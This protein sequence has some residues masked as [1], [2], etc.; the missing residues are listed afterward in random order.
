MTLYSVYCR[1]IVLHVRPISKDSVHKWGTIYLHALWLQNRSAQCLEDSQGTTRGICISSYSLKN[2]VC[3][4]FKSHSSRRCLSSSF[5]VVLSYVGRCLATGWS[6]IQGI[7]PVFFMR[8]NS[9]KIVYLDRVL[10]TENQ[11]SLVMWFVQIWDGVI[12]ICRYA[13]KF[14]CGLIKM[15]VKTVILF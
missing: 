14:T 13:A 8:E 7:V 2:M 11:I 10:L 1:R 12:T 15:F 6:L 4:G 9:R 3:Y 5:S